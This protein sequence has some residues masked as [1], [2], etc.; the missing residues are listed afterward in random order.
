M[1]ALQWA[2]GA[3]VL[4]VLAVAHQDRPLMHR[5][6]TVTALLSLAAAGIAR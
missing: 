1:T 4:A 2:A 6:L 5:I 3:L